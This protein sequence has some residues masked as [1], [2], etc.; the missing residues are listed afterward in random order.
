MWSDVFPVGLAKKDRKH[1]WVF[2]SYTEVPSEREDKCWYRVF[3]F[4]SEDR[5]IFGLIE[6][7]DYPQI[8]FHKLATR[9]IQDK[10]FRESLV[11]S[12]SD[13]PKIWKRH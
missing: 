13:L 4:R 5:E 8:D 11:S 9:V 1:H 3:L 12:D 7:Q 2:A 10:E 6:Y